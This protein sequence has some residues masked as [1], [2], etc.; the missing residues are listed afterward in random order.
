MP[1]SPLRAAEG[2]LRLGITSNGAAL[3]DGV[4]IQSCVIHRSFNAIPWA[5]IVILDGDMPTGD[6]PVS[7]LALF[8][9]GAAITISAGYGDAEESL[10]SGVVLRHSLDIEGNRPSLLVVECRDKAAAMTLR[11]HNAHFTD[12]TD[13]SIMGA[14]IGAY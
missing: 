11:R 13:S 10:F 2:V 8:A 12:Q 1:D 4:Q 6:F 9:P 5:R 7:D 14:V 3:P